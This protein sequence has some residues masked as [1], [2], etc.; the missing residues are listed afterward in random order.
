MSWIAVA[1]KDFRDAV[2][3]RALWALLAVFVLFSVATTYAYVELPEAFGATGEVS[4]A[5]LLFFLAGITAL[6][7]ALAAIV[8]CYKSLAGEREL[9]SIKLLLALPHTRRDVFVGKVIGR[10]AVIAAA[11][12]VGLLVGLGVGS[13]LLG[14]TDVV[15]L[16]TFVLA[17]AV[18]AGIYATIVVGLSATT[19]S[20]SRATTLAL[21]FFVVFELAWDVVPLALVYVVNGF[22]LPPAGQYPDWMFLVMQVPPSSA[23]FAALV[24]L[25][26]DVAAEAG[27]QTQAAGFDAFYATPEIGFVVLAFWLVVPLAVGYYRF[28]GADL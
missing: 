5:G 10:A 27:A 8:V 18:F 26:P 24:A 2:Q 22:S 20:T 1:K 21:G 16:V 28:D 23:Y 19:G 12:G 7:V 17:A 14:T 13:L 3:S 11:L 15:P 9:G 25:L 4:F 6:F